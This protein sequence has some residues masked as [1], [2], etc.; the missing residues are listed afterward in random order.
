MN[1]GCTTYIT[2]SEHE[3]KKALAQS[4]QPSGEAAV[5]KSAEFELDHGTTEWGDDRG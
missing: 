5:F 4:I 3:D 2:R 1:E